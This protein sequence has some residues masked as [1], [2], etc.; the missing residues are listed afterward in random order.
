MLR[1]K[2]R[3]YRLF[4][5]VLFP[6]AVYIEINFNTTTSKQSKLL[7]ASGDFFLIFLEPKGRGI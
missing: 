7:L 1:D 4:F 3:S 2:S 5:K 6:K